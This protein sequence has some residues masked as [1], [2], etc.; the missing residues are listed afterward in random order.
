M[1]TNLSVDVDVENPDSITDPSVKKHQ[2]DHA[3]IHAYTNTHDTA[4]DPHGDRAYVN[5]LPLTKT[6]VFN[7]TTYVAQAVKHFVGSADPQSISGIVL[8][9]HDIW[10]EEL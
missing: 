6:Y 9:A 8:A 10:D 1:A 2:Q 4:N 3:A 5:A 7:G